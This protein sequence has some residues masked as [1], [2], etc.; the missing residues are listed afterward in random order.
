[1]ARFYAKVQSEWQGNRSYQ[2]PWLE[3]AYRECAFARIN[4][5]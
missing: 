4:Y 3:E 2:A 5:C 1:M